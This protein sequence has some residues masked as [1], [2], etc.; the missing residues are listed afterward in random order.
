ML[1]II[2]FL[3]AYLFAS[4]ANAEVNQTIINANIEK[5]INMANI[6]LSALRIEAFGPHFTPNYLRH[7]RT[8]E[9][10]L[11]A[12]KARFR[13]QI[14]LALAES[15][16]MQIIVC[17]YGHISDQAAIAVVGELR[18]NNTF[19]AH[20]VRDVTYCGP[21]HRGYAFVN[22]EETSH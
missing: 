21:R 11:A 17:P 6:E 3:I 8:K 7:N 18:H 22:L 19:D 1:T 9:N 13:A 16:D 20:W 2:V 5:W 14:G 10:A 15:L 4:A 12:Q